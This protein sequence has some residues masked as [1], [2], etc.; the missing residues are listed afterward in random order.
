MG[1][2][3]GMLKISEAQFVEHAIINKEMV[4]SEN[5]HDEIPQCVS[6]DCIQH[7]LIAV[8]NI[9]EFLNNDPLSIRNKCQSKC[10]G[11]S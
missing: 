11:K 6:E 8:R 7:H 4:V 3:S 9:S 1:S 10:H 2:E 5:L